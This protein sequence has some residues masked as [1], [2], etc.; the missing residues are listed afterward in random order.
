MKGAVLII[1]SLLWDN[2]SK[3][4]DTWRS[5][6]L[7][8]EARIPVQAPIWYG[9]RSQSRGNTYTMTFR[10]EGPL[11]VAML[12][13]CQRAIE[14]IDDLRSEAHALWKAEAPNADPEAIG[15]NWGCV[16]VLFANDQATESLAT[17]WSACFQRMYKSRIPA[18]SLDGSLEIPPLERMNY[19]RH[20]VDIILGTAT[21]P[22]P[23]PPS[24]NDVA[25]AWIGQDK[26]HERY[27]LENVRHGI[28]TA[29]DAEIWAR[30]E[31]KSP[32]WL[33]NNDY[34]D[35]ISKLRSEAFHAKGS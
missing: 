7:N 22:E 3:G 18:V 30:I 8:L 2:D 23:T 10:Q 34:I 19:A 12:V 28:R 35:T 9:R 5:Q 16:G 27:F 1:G 15:A 11:G 25:D 24:A 17:H 4:R 14:T 31:T 32:A 33:A 20:D 13:P 26:G 6:R 21:A 29:A